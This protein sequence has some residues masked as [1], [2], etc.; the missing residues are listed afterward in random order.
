LLMLREAAKRGSFRGLAV[1]VLASPTTN[2]P[3][4]QAGSI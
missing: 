2:Q 3:T 4:G 1:Y